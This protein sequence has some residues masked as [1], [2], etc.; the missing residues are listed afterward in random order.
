MKTQAYIDE[1]VRIDRSAWINE[2]NAFKSAIKTLEDIYGDTIQGKPSDTVDRFIAAVGITLARAVVAT[3]V[4]RHAW[5]G[6][7]SKRVSDWAGTVFNAF[8]ESVSNTH[9][10]YTDRIHMTHLDQIANE[11][12]KREKNNAQ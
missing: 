9:F 5:D 12:V 8:E 11:F 2:Y 4:I 6:R 3:L 10:F 7:I 1:L